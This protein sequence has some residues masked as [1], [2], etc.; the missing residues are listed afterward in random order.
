[1]KNRI[2]TILFLT[3]SAFETLSAQNPI[4][5]KQYSADPSAHVFNGRMFV[6]PSHDRDDSKTFD[7][8][9]YHVYSSDNMKDWVDHGMALHLDSITWATEK[10]WAPDCGYKNGK[11]YFYFPTDRANIGVAVGDS[12][13]GPFKD[14]LGKPL[15]TKNDPGVINQRDFIDPTI[16]IDDDGSPYLFFGQLD[17]NVVKLNE[18]MLSYDGPVHII[19]GAKDFFEAIWIHK[20]NNNYYLSYSTWG[21]KG[22]TGPQIAYATSKNILGPYTY[23]GVILDEVNSGTNHHSIVEFKG[24]W[25]LFYHNSDLFL[26]RTPRNSPNLKAAPYRRSVCV[27]YLYHNPDGS[28]NKVVPTKK[29][30]KK[31]K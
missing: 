18:D 27:D 24:Q 4:I 15:L 30:V 8:M 29:S 11:Y 23:Q 2:S 22:I 14:A 28:I 6:Y 26:K 9:D 1:M 21:E 12:P 5:T 16:F 20:Y 7:M 19:K 10:A 17:V 25:Y 13:R 3:I 31:T